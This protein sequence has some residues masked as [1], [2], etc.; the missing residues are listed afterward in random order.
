MDDKQRIAH[1]AERMVR[2]FSEKIERFEEMVRSAPQSCEDRLNFQLT[3]LKS[4][5]RALSLRLQEIKAASNRDWP[6]MTAGLDMAKQLLEQAWKEASQLMPA[7]D[8]EKGKAESRDN[9]G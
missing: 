9:G 3:Q 2:E 8:P 1:D 4:R 5:R 7:K 6:N